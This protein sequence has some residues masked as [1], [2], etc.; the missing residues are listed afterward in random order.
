MS[1]PSRP[2]HASL[3]RSDKL[4]P[5]AAPGRTRRDSMTRSGKQ[6]PANARFVR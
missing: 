2:K 5:T 1:G 3:A 4:R 6:S